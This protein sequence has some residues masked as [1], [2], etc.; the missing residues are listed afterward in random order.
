MPFAIVQQASALIT[1]EAIVQAVN[2]KAGVLET[3]EAIISSQTASKNGYII[4]TVAPCWQGG[5]HNEQELLKNCYRNALK[6][7]AK[8]KLKSIQFELNAYNLYGYPKELALEAAMQSIV[9]FLHNNSHE[10]DI[11]LAVLERVD[12]AINEQL[13]SEVERFIADNT[14]DHRAPT[15]ETAFFGAI[16]PFLYNTKIESS[17]ILRHEGD[18]S[19]R[20]INDIDIDTESSDIDKFPRFDRFQRYSCECTPIFINPEENF[21]KR[22]RRYIIMRNMDDVTVYKRAN[23]TR[24]H[25]SK[26]TGRKPYQPSKK[27]ALALAIALELNLDDTA[28]LLRSAGFALS[29]SFTFD[30]IIEYFIVHNNYNMIDINEVLFKYE[31]PLLGV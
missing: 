15:R 3:G 24:Q 4:S 8:H 25:W 31:Q 9:E 12:L 6:L 5:D 11:T 28:D 26:L 18:T 17:S 16:S 23:I 14:D 10:M 30:L 13:L 2:R 19:V 27:T 29:H 7:A 21:A 1:A 22:L 20:S